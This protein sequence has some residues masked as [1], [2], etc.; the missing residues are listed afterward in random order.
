MVDM[1]ERRKFVKF[2]WRFCEE[3]WCFYVETFLEDK[4]VDGE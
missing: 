2:R 3:L 4:L 1:L